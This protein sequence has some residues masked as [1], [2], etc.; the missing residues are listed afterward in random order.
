VFSKSGLKWASVENPYWNIISL[1]LKN[2]LVF[3]SPLTLV[4]RFL[5]RPL[6]PPLLGSLPQRTQPNELTPLDFLQYLEF[7]ILVCQ[8]LLTMTYLSSLSLSPSLCLLH[9][10]SPSLPPFLSF[11]SSL[12]PSFFFLSPILC[13]GHRR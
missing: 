9:S 8:G 12:F 13:G 6:T 10:L 7:L 5:G 3:S 1:D 2:L 11:L 4:L